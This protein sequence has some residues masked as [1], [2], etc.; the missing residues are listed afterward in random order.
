MHRRPVIAAVLLVAC[1]AARVGAQCEVD[2]LVEPVAPVDQ[3]YDGDVALHGGVAVVGRSNSIFGNSPSWVFE[4]EPGGWGAGS[5][6]PPDQWMTSYGDSVS[7]WGDTAVV[8][9]QENNDPGVGALVFERVG[10]AWVQSTKLHVPDP[11]GQMSPGL[12]VAIEEDTILVADWHLNAVFVFERV[13]G[14]WSP[15]QT[16]T[17]AG[18]SGV[19]L[20]GQSVSLVGGR[21]VVGGGTQ[22]ASLGLF[23]RARVFERLGG[24]FVPVAELVPSGGQEWDNA[25][26]DVAQSGDTIVLG[27]P[28]HGA[29]FPITG[30]GVVFVFELV[31]GT[32][33]QTAVVTAAP[34]PQLYDSF[35]VAVALQDDLL[36]VGAPHHDGALDLSNSGAVYAYRRAGSEWQHIATLQAGE[37]LAYE[38]FGFALALEGDSLLVGAQPPGND[39]DHV[40]AYVV[41]GMLGLTDWLPFGGAVAGSGA[42]C[43]FGT[44]SPAVG[45]PASVT[46][47]GALPG[48][49]GW[50]VLGIAR[51]NAPFKG[52]VLV[53]APQLLLPKLADAA[54]GASLGWTW[55]PGLPPG[56][57][58]TLQHWM[59]DAGAPLGW[60]GSQALAVE[61]P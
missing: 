20:F 46:L 57:V 27:A 36:V 29:G 7:V 54:G 18:M 45:A 47:V 50:L 25:G 35:G 26:F 2:R 10:G 32:W 40:I 14:V 37:P 41:R 11:V 53:P 6:L 43:L 55:P 21:A 28:N 42:P 30:I 59:M 12:S 19:Y 4:L 58:L 44:G 34:G 15:V 48:G 38:R 24:A 5:A 61:V 22:V 49:P 8:A 33:T 3:A 17:A 1:L 39:R 60:A 31:G 56:L 52:G 9:G 16:L 23:G 13:A 51:I